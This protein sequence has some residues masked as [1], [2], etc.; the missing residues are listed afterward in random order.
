M[1]VFNFFIVIPQI[2]AAAILGFFIKHIF[3]E[4]SIFALVI[5]GVSM[6]LAGLLNVIVT[7]RDDEKIAAKP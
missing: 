5:G 1:G 4:Q 7:D 2:V 3:N 6:I